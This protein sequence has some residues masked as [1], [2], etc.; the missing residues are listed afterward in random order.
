MTAKGAPL[1]GRRRSLSDTP[2][3]F[4]ASRT[5]TARPIA[6]YELAGAPHAASERG[7]RVGAGDVDLTL[8]ASLVH[9]DE[10]DLDAPVGH[11]DQRVGVATVSSDAR[12]SGEPQ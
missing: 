1:D 7:A 9:F 12:G 8:D 2:L 10:L 3:R 5:R 11:L 4:E 6:Y